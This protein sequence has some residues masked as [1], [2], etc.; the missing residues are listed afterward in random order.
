MHL[1]T[2]SIEKW[3]LGI[4]VHYPAM[5]ERVRPCRGPIDG[6]G[7]PEPL[8]IHR[9]DERPQAAGMPAAPCGHSS[10]GAGSFGDGKEK[11]GFFKIWI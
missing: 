1:W 9:L 4:L 8:D 11:N 7:R 5:P 10:H 2:L 6:M 3:I